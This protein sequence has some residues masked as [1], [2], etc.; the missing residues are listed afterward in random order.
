M[1][2]QEQKI[3]E[4]ELR[5]KNLELEIEL[6]KLKENNPISYSAPYP[7]PEP[8]H[9]APMFPGQPWITWLND[10]TAKSLPKEPI[11]I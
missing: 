6:L 5:I 3:K 8:Y 10:D 9:P 11:F 4:L 1:A 2:K 7:C